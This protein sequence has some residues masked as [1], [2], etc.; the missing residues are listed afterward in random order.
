MNEPVLVIMAAGMGSRFGGLKQITS[1]DK[2]EHKIIDF[3]LYD[4]YRAGFRKVVFIIKHEI[5]ADFKAAIGSR[6]E[7]YFSVRYVFQE[8]DKLPEGYEVPEGRTKPWGT[9]HAIACAKDSID[10]PFAVINADDYYGVHAMDSIYKFLKEEHAPT[11]HAMVGYLV[12]NTVTE[13]GYVSRGVCH[14]EGGF[15]KDIVERTHIERRGDDAEFTEDG[16]K[17]WTHLSGND[18]VSMNLWGFQHEILSQFT[19]RFASFLDENLP[20]N[21][22]KC[23]YFLPFVADRQI[24][25]GLG[26]VRMLTTDDRWY[27]VTY[28]EDLKSVMDAVVSMKSEGIYPDELWLSPAAAYHFRIEGAPFSC[29][30]HGCGHINDTYLLTSTTGKR[31]ILQ[32]IS[33]TFDP[34]TLMENIEAVLEFSA[35]KTDDP[36]GVMTLVRTLDGKS[37]YEDETVAY[38]M[39]DFIEHSLCLQAPE[40]P[41]DFYESA[42]AFGRFSEMMSEFPAEKLHETIANFHNT[43]DRYRIFK[44][45]LEKDPL[46]RK[47]GVPDEI[48]FALAREGEAGILVDLLEAGQLPLRVTHN[49]TKLNNVMLDETTR[50]ALCVIDLDT[51]MPGLSLYDYG[52]SIR[53]GAATATENELDLENM[54][55]DLELFRIYTRGFLKACP[56]LTDKEIELMPTG[57]KLMTLECGVRFLTDYIDGDNYFHID[58]E[59]QN[60]E[61]ARTQFKLVEEMEKHWD[62][63]T[64]IVEEERR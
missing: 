19:G 6:M 34:E 40:T 55:I 14:A 64:A 10:G 45:T 38:R 9:A 21:P 47:A 44:E 57:A 33:K 20:K 5:E 39:Y 48:A 46:G 61:R 24:K 62:E 43:K 4:A 7:K 36:R 11:E 12:K 31:Y 26:T 13:S 23:E 49:D 58:H 63:M 29:V 42:I 51:V 41:Q 32:R 60:L 50:K 1:I 27:G 52:D 17:T 56:N 2:E 37:Y 59:T 54:T 53:F 16:G 18:I 25:E 8:L 28:P 30:S 22:L 35:S 3:S 15:L